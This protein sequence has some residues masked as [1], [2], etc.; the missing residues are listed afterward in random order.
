MA[1][2]KERETLF[3]STPAFKRLITSKKAEVDWINRKAGSYL[4]GHH[5]LG[6]LLDDELKR[7]S[8]AVKD[9]VMAGK[10]GGSGVMMT[11]IMIG[12]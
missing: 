1:V 4:D 7:R 11:A 12:R 2:A 9:A 8:S 6:L 10:K 5:G 3:S